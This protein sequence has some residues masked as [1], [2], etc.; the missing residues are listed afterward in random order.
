M[1]RFHLGLAAAIVSACSLGACG[2]ED[3]TEVGQSGAQVAT[4]E[5]S[6]SSPT[7]T[8]LGA[9]VQLSAVAKDASG[10]MI[11]GKTFTWTSSAEGVATVQSGVVTAVANGTATITATTD[12]VS[13]ST[14]ITVNQTVS[15]VVVTPP[16]ATLLKADTTRLTAS[17][18]DANGNQ[19][20]ADPSVATVDAAGLVTGVAMGSTTITATSDGGVE[21]SASITVSVLGLVAVSAGGQHTCGVA[22]SGTAYCWGSNSGGQLGIGMGGDQAT[23]AVVSGG[24]LFQSVDAGQ[25]HTCGITTSGDARAATLTAGAEETMASSVRA[26]RHRV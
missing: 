14:D 17:P 1:N 18:T 20:S 7:L 12:A 24:L 11:S 4:V 10:N 21:G 19:A 13:G 26:K 23:P 22:V 15:S 9:S 8:A 6:P 25:D 16:T 5:V 3:P 2:G